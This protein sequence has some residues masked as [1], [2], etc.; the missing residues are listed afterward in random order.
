MGVRYRLNVSW[1]IRRGPAWHAVVGRHCRL[2]GDIMVGKGVSMMWMLR[3]CLHDVECHGTV[4][5]QHYTCMAAANSLC[6]LKRT[7][8][9]SYVLLTCGFVGDITSRMGHTSAT[10]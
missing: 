5:A 6:Q 9:C 2:H 8:I 1:P 4:Q 3:H 10:V 7:T